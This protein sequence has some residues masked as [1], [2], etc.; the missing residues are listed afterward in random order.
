MKKMMALTITLLLMMATLV[1]CGNNTP[2]T[3]PSTDD[4]SKTTVATEPSTDPIET[5]TATEPSTDPIEIPTSFRSLPSPENLLDVYR[6]EVE[7][8][9]ATERYFTFE[10]ENFIES[11]GYNAGYRC[12]QEFSDTLYTYHYPVVYR[13]GDEMVIA[14]SRGGHLDFE[15]EDEVT[16]NLWNMHGSPSVHVPQLTA[17]EKEIS[18]ARGSMVYNSAS[19]SVSFWEFGQLV[20]THTVP[21]GAGYVG[22]SDDEGYLF[23]LDAAVYAVA[24]EGSRKIADGVSVVIL[25]DY[26]D[27]SDFGSQPLFLMKDGTLK[28]YS[29]W[30]GDQQAPADDPCHL[31]DI[32]YE[33]GYL[34][35]N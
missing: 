11:N 16:K 25:A 18:R 6:K 1:A 30:Y 35:N 28:V 24:L 19:G 13:V 33:G 23:R 21:A 10:E 31:Q 34:A 12:I 7:Y 2:S 4:S 22:L 14:Y 27:S 17:E 3:T 26:Y 32:S 29:S 15:G 8:R 9:I 5:T 20:A